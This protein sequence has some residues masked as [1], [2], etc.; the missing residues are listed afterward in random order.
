MV[1]CRNSE[2]NLVIEIIP[3][4]LIINKLLLIFVKYFISG[5]VGLNL[6]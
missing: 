6:I 3:S 4:P 5:I 2:K 1:R